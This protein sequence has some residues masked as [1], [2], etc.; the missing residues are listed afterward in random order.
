MALS[1]LFDRAAARR[2]ADGVRESTEP[3]TPATV[4]SWVDSWFAD[5]YGWPL[6]TAE[7]RQRDQFLSWVIDEF[8]E[9]WT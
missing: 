2:V 3:T 7:A 9:A 1:K 8:A 6:T 5:V 4:Q